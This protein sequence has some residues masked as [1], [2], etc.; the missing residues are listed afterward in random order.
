MNSVLRP[1]QPS[2]VYLVGCAVLFAASA[3]TTSSGGGGS[4]AVPCALDGSCPLNMVCS[5]TIC[6]ANGDAFGGGAGDTAG[7]DGAGAA[8]AGGGTGGDAD[9]APADTA[10]ADTAPADIAPADTAPADTAPADTAPADT[11][12]ADTAQT[13]TSPA[14]TGGSDAQGA[15]GVSIAGLQQGT[16]SV[17]CAKTDGEA[18]TVSAAN[19]EVGIATAPIAALGTLRVFYLRPEGAPAQNGSY[20]GIKVVVFGKEPLAVA[21]GDRVRVKGDVVEYF[22]ETEIKTDAGK[23]EVLGQSSFAPQPYVVSTGDL[24]ASSAGSEKFEGVYVELQNVAIVSAN[25]IGSDGKP[26]GS[27]AVAQIGSSSP[28]VHVGPTAG[29]TFTK[30]NPKTGETLTVFVGNEVFASIRGHLTYSFGTFQ[31]RP[32]SSADLVAK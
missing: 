9:A 24:A 17:V 21:A 14:D 3:C 10:P 31:L 28:E 20:Q 30:K 26:H 22:C 2:L 11:A 12:P 7:G 16:A 5:G 18:T 8:D 25:V 19:L 15:Q 4:L 32:T 27:F 1:Q 23:V 13:D 6:V 29:T